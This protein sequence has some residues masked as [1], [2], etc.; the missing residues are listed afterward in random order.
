MLENSCGLGGTLLFRL[1][2]DQCC[3]SLFNQTRVG[4]A[5]RKLGIRIALLIR[6]LRRRNTYCAAGSEDICRSGRFL[7][8]VVGQYLR[9]SSVRRRCF[10]RQ[11]RPEGHRDTRIVGL[12]GWLV[13]MR[14]VLRNAIGGSN[15]RLREG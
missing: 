4:G 10:E 14:W 15:G 6:E 3:N 9:F 12:L 7:D 5:F 11:E 8:G 2:Y 1:G 13:L